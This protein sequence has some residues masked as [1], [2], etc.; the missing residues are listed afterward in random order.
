MTVENERLRGLRVEEENHRLR[1]RMDAALAILH[2]EAPARPGPPVAAFPNDLAHFVAAILRDQAVLDL[3]AE[4][5]RLRGI[6]EE[7]ERF[8][9]Q[10]RSARADLDR[11]RIVLQNIDDQG[12]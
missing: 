4:N 7:N 10:M 2:G 12:N 3:E 9:E 1:E 6:Q 8:R 11:A 5:R